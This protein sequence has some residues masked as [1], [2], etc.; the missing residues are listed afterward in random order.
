VIVTEDPVGNRQVQTTSG[1]APPGPGSI[2]YTYD[3]R[4]RL[5]TENAT[6]YGWDDNGNLVSKSGEATYVWD[7]EN[8]LIRV[9]KLD[10]T[11]VT[12]AYDADGNRVR[13]E[14]T[15]ATGPPTVTDYLLDTSGPL[16]QVVAETDTTGAVTAYYVRG[17]DLLSVL[18]PALGNQTRFYHADGL[19]SIRRLTDEAGSVTDSYTYTAFGELLQHL[20]SDPQPYQCKRPLFPF[21]RRASAW[22]MLPS[23]EYGH[24]RRRRWREGWI[25]GGWRNEGT[26]GRP[27]H[28]WWLTPGGEAASRCRGSRSAVELTPSGLRGG[29]RDWARSRWGLGHRCVFTRCG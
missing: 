22:A 25:C 9:E 2:S 11:I 16:S 10:G 28:G 24:G 7:F 23:P 27:R 13:T 14:V 20:G 6:A 18:R 21:S 8:R 5:L 17:D 29:P 26:G 15:P 12:H 3:T 1:T 4:D 19:G